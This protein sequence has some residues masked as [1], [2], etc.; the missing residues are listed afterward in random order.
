L[1]TKGVIIPEDLTA[2]EDQIRAVSAQFQSKS[3][4]LYVYANTG[5][6][7]EGVVSRHDVFTGKIV[8]REQYEGEGK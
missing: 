6:P 8:T 4:S 1:I 5:L 2:A 7:V 3:D